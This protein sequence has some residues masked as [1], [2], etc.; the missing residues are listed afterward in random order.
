[1]AEHDALPTQAKKDLLIEL[2]SGRYDHVLWEHSARTAQDALLI[3]DL[4]E[5]NHA[6]CQAIYAAG[7]YHDAGWVVQY[8]EGSVERLEILSHPTGDIQRD[9][10]ADLLERNLH[11]VLPADSRRQAAETVRQMN[12]RHATGL[13]TRIVAD[14]ENLQAVGPLYLWQLVRRMTLEGR[15]VEAAIETWRRQNEYKYW[16]ARLH[17]AFH[18]DVVRAVAIRRQKQ[19]HSF[20]SAL[21]QDHKANDLQGL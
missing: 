8:G 18:F 4:I 16:E 15:G 3:A 11:N 14:A 5:D 7:L 12:D 10:G 19:M 13:E 20:M 1:M 9:L 21:E 6:D 2:E 17:D